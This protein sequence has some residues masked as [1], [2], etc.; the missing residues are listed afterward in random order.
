MFSLYRWVRLKLMHFK[1]RPMRTKKD[2]KGKWKHYTR[3]VQCIQSP[4][5]N[6]RSFVCSNE[7]SCWHVGNVALVYYPADRNFGLVNRQAGR[8]ASA[9]ESLTY[10]GRI[11]MERREANVSSHSIKTNARSYWQYTNNRV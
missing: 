7:L 5:Y 1:V 4:V 6:Q 3:A 9:K 10:Y 11:Q 2:P 8:Q